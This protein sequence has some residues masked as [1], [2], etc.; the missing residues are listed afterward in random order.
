MKTLISILVGLFVTLGLWVV[1]NFLYPAFDAALFAGHRSDWD[2]T[3]I[4]GLAFILIFV[5]AGLWVGGSYHATH[6]V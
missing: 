1:Y 3:R 6:K 2:F 4:P 5:G